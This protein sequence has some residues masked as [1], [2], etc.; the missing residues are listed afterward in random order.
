MAGKRFEIVGT[1]YNSVPTHR[2]QTAAAATIIEKGM[3]LKKTGAGS[4]YVTPL[5]TGDFTI[6]TDVAIVGLA[7]NDSTHTASVDGVIDVYLPL[8]GLLY[9]GYATTAAN[10][11]TRA[12]LDLLRGDRVDITVSATTSAGNWTINEDLGDTVA[13]AFQII[14]GDPVK[15]TIDFIIR[16]GATSLDDSTIA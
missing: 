16:A 11:D 6:A 4:P 7:A 5:V 13:Q 8:P 10:I 12:E 1:P 2:W 14:D 9:R 3:L 15:G